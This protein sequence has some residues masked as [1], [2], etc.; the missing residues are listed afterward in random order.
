[1]DFRVCKYQ[2]TA[3]YCVVVASNWWCWDRPVS[4][5]LPPPQV[6]VLCYRVSREVLA[7]AF[8]ESFQFASV[9]LSQRLRLKQRK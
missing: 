9:F 5:R 8:C 7:V 3:G 4:Y 2:G 1:M 6:A